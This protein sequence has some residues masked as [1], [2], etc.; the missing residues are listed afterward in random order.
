MTVQVPVS[1]HLAGMGGATKVTQLL[2]V[3]VSRLCNACRSFE[4]PR[5]SRQKSVNQASMHCHA[6]NGTSNDI[7]QPLRPQPHTQRNPAHRR[8]LETKRVHTATKHDC[9]SLTASLRRRG[10]HQH[11]S[12]R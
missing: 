6:T 5:Q 3:S 10:S 9:P 11:P 7:P 2:G 1:I 12:F 8:T 4:A